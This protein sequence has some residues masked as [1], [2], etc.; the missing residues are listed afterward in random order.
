MIKNIIILAVTFCSLTV[1]AQVQPVG[2]QIHLKTPLG[3]PYHG[4]FFC[5]NAFF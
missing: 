4:L 1:A 5:D 3:V 2:R